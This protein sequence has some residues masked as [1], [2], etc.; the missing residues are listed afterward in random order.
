MMN[1]DKL[2]ESVIKLR[3]RVNEY[4]QKRTKFSIHFISVEIM[5]CLVEFSLLTNDPIK[6]ITK[7][8]E[9]WFNAGYYV[10]LLFRNSEWEDIIHLYYDI[11][12]EVEKENFFRM[13]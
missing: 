12:D 5:L 2:N 9:K 1:N 10:D 3:K 8:E 6:P 11:K 7:D 13:A 4:R